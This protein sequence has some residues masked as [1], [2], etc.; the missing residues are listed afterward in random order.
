MTDIIPFLPFSP[1][2]QAAVADKSLSEFGRELV[3]PIDITEEPS[4][5]W[6]AGNINLRIK[7]GYSVCKALA[8]E[9][10][11]KE[12]G[13]RSIINT[14]DRDIRKPLISGYLASRDTIREDQSA[15]GF[16]VGVDDR[17]LVSVSEVVE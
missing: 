15:A 17:G 16:V 7:Q 3:K 2:E 6:P 13:A 12:L 1:V 5:Y 10:Y 8:E 9:G 11:V 4:R 14:I